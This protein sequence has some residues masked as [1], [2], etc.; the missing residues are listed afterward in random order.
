MN[1]ENKKPPKPSI[2]LTAALRFIFENPPLQ[3]SSKNASM[4]DEL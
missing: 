1:D 3:L 2:R 4:K